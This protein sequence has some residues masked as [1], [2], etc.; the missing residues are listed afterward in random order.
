MNKQ[1]RLLVGLTFFLAVLY[2][3]G[4]GVTG[5]L[6]LVLGAPELAIQEWIIGLLF[7]LVTLLLAKVIKVEFVHGYLE[8]ALKV[9]VPTLIG[10]IGSGTI[11]F[12][13]SCLILSLVFKQNISALLVTGAGS[14]AILGFALKDFAVAL[15]SGISLNFEDTLKVGDRIRVLVDQGHEGVVQKITWR[16]TVLLTDHLQTVFIPNVKLSN[17]TIINFD[18]P[19][20]SVKRLLKL[21][22]DYDVSVDSVERVLY[23]GALNAVGV[24]Y[25]AS[26]VVRATELKESGIEYVI[27]YTITDMRDRLSAEHALIKSVLESLRVANI[28]VARGLDFD[29]GVRIANRSL[30][31]YHLAQQIKLFSNM[32]ADLLNEISLALTPVRYAPSSKVVSAG[33]RDHSLYIVAE[34]ILSRPQIGDDGHILKQ[35]FVPTEFFGVEA[36]FSNLPHQSTVVAET[37]ALIYQLTKTAL[38][39]ILHR[40]P[41]LVGIFSANLSSLQAEDVVM[42]VPNDSATWAYKKSLYE[43]IIRANYGTSG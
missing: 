16:N 43:G 14:A 23:A 25:A 40:H 24:K 21:E 1:Y 29:R 8:Q 17:A 32:G 11:I 36:L 10:D 35:R 3:L 33:D 5:P 7:F 6:S 22:I 20:R 26:P 39:Q 12:T 41:A 34:G 9:K 30:D 15:A 4:Q 42:L 31:V 37:D 18:L 38:H 27:T 19:N 13:G 28:T 2:S